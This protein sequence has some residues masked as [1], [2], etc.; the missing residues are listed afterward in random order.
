M[1]YRQV[2]GGLVRL[3]GWFS[4][5]KQDHEFGE[6]LESHLQMHIEDILRQGHTPEE[7]RRQA[8]I[9]LGGIEQTKERY[10]YQRRI[11]LFETLAQDLRF[12][13]RRLGKRPGFTLIA[14]L[15]L[16]LGVSANTAIFTL[17]NAALLRPLPYKDAERI[18]VLSTIRRDTGEA[19]S[20]SYPDFLDWR[21]QNTVFERLAAYTSASFSLSASDVLERVNGELVSAEYF[22]LLGVQAASGRTFLAEE[23]RTPDTH[24]V[25]LV[26]HGLWQR[27]FG[28][29][30]TLVG[31]TIQLSAVN[32]TV[33]G[34]MPEGFRGISDQAEIWLPM[35]MVS[36]VRRASSL[37]EREQR[38]HSIIGRLKPAVTLAQ[39]RAEM[40][41]ITSRLEQEYPNSNSNRGAGITLL[42]ERYFGNLQLTLWVLL[43]A[44]GCVLLVACANV[45]N[46]QLQ[47]AAGRASEIAVRL[48]L[49]A[50]PRRLVQQ[51]LT[52]SLLLAFIGGGLGVL[53]AFWSV[54]FLI[55]LSPMT[56]PSFVKLTV[57]GRVLG[58]SLLLSML[59][60]VMFGLAPALQAVKPALNETLKTGGRNSSG[61]LGRN[62]LL[63]ALVVSEIALALT[64]LI[65]AG[66]MIRS[67]QRLQAVDPGFNSEGLLTMQ[68]SL[69]MQTYQREQVVIFSQQL[70]ERLQ[71]MP[72]AQSVTVASDL[73]LCGDTSGGPVE[74][75]GQSATPAGGETR[76]YRHR[77][78][79]G[80]FSALGIPLIKGRDFTDGDQA[81]APGVAIIS[82]AMARRYWPN[83]DPIGKR[84]R[85]DSRGSATPAPWLTI[86]GVVGEVKYRGL[87][88]NPNTDPDVYFP[89]PQ[90][91]I[92]DLYL[93]VRSNADTGNLVGAVRAELQKLDPSLP[94]YGV[95]TMEERLANQTR[96]SRFSAWVLGIFGAIALVLAAVGIYSVMSYAVEQR[97]RE[98]GIRV[99]LGAGAGDVLKMVIRQGM[100]LALLGIVLGLGMALVLTQL[101]KQLLSGM[102]TVDPPTY[103]VL[104]SILTVVALLACWIPARRATQVDPIIALRYE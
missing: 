93:A 15:T 74:L 86:V 81:Q 98:I 7:A 6:E 92:R 35:M 96:Q 38:W 46:L 97:S 53:L 99:A 83:E 87:P 8:L 64:L 49:G 11:P 16:A 17:I 54:D 82:E 60:G 95:R 80:F 78:T 40:E 51:L 1:R 32:Y 57:D 39:A 14:I 103:T 37:Q 89:L 44:V 61:G 27:S 73:P 65:G 85:E 22:P 102:A 20:S 41:A 12:G 77:V 72:G 67:L 18:A 26:G 62:R 94:V 3:A 100:K 47:Q 59:S 33:I 36:S 70:R 9:K 5:E 34:I 104:A 23:D 43:G 91:P 21:N 55:K 90:A 45:A 13:L 48:A 56:F 79:Q 75:E 29:S 68:V 24:R 52:E 25:A 71:A 76:M 69:P 84:L 30:P 88:H 42:H 4:R 31:Q 2:R 50:T 19:R 10:R 63:S 66:L 58:F 101:M 28:G